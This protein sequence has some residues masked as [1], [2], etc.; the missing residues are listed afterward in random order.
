MGD[1]RDR[2]TTRARAG[3]LVFCALLA[4]C[5]G[6]G[7]GDNNGPA[8]ASS[9]VSVLIEPAAPTVIANTPQPFIATVTGATNTAV[10]WSVQEAGGGDISATGLYTAPAAPGTY[11]VVATSQEDP[12]GTATVAVTVEQ[13]QP[14]T[15][16]ISPSG[17]VPVEVE[18]GGSQTFLATVTGTTNTAVTWSVQPGGAG[19]KINPLGV[20]SDPS[21]PGVDLV[22]ATSVV[23]PTKFAQVTV[24]IVATSIMI[25]PSDVRV[26]LGGQVQF[27]LTRLVGGAWSLSGDSKFGTISV[28]VGLYTAP[29]QMPTSNTAIEVRHISTTDKAVITLASRFLPPETLPV[30][31]CGGCE[32]DLPNAIVAEDFNG[33][34]LD[35]LATANSGTGTLSILIAA[36]KSHFGEAVRPQVGNLASGDPEALAVADLNLVGGVVDLVVADADP[37]G[38]AVRSFL[39]EGDGTFGSERASALSSNSNPLSVAVGLMDSDAFPDVAVANFLTSTVE[40]LQ[41]V[42]DGT[43]RSYTPPTV[44]TNG[45]SGPLGIVAASFNGDG[46]DDLAVAN[47]QDG[48]VSIFLSNANGT[49]AAPQVVS[50]GQNSPSA[51]AAVALTGGGNYLDLVVTTAFN[52]KLTPLLNSSGTFTASPT[53]LSTGTSPVAVAKG[54]FNKDTFQDVVVANQGSN[55]VTTYLG[56]GGGS[57]VQSETYNVG[58]QPQAVAVGDFNGD[59]WSDVA[60]ANNGDDT[61]S[62]LRNRGSPTAP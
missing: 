26:G 42:G 37:S 40:V 56:Q 15:V 24:N 44:L 31:G 11:H 8:C 21:T 48:T 23:D 41:G 39:G 13:A 27:S 61:V 7:G 35:D 59:G 54:D 20:Y 50:L 55:S 43:F 34:G 57:L 5:S 28:G 49:F 3:A 9:T 46:W 4:A 38:L 52:S 30:D 12:C 53:P 29:F 10:T 33:D 62:I 58:L 2:R 18:V 45:V 51:L 47:S 25:S 14:I 1:V 16:A 22:T 17:S 36:D 19:G 60:V 32:T 6:G